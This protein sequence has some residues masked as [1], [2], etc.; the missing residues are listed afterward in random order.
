MTDIELV[1]KKGEEDRLYQWDTDRQ[2]KITTDLMVDEVQFDT[3]LSKSLLVKPRVDVELGGVVADIPNILL[4]GN[5]EINVY[6]HQLLIH[7][8]CIY[9]HEWNSTLLFHLLFFFSQ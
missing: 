8:F 1:V 5:M 9:H 7:Q 2:I 6:V 3:I 4:Q